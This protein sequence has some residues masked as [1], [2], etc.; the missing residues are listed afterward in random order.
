[1]NL[2]WSV[3]EYIFFSLLYL[4]VVILFMFSLLSLYI[5][6]TVIIFLFSTCLCCFVYTGFAFWLVYYFN[7]S[8]PIAWVIGL[9]HDC[10]PYLSHLLVFIWLSL[11]KIGRSLFVQLIIFCIVICNMRCKCRLHCILVAQLVYT[12][13][14]CSIKLGRFVCSVFFYCILSVLII[15]EC[16]YVRVTR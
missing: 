2:R 7:L 10:M 6:S 9:L 4:I 8:L 5:L 16:S 1:M 3:R 12:Y 13:G 14:D 11:S 15:S